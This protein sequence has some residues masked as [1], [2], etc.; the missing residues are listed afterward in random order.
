MAITEWS[1]TLSG[2]TSFYSYLGYSLLIINRMKAGHPPSR[3]VKNTVCAH[4]RCRMPWIFV[5][6][7]TYICTYTNPGA[8][9]CKLKY[10]R[11]SSC[12]PSMTRHGG[13]P[14]RV[15]NSA[16]RTH[17]FWLPLRRLALETRLK[18][19][20]PKNSGWNPNGRSSMISPIWW[21]PGDRPRTPI[22]L[23]QWFCDGPGGCFT[24][25]QI[26]LFTN[27]HLFCLRTDRGGDFHDVRLAGKLTLYW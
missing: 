27:S 26:V 21:Y 11:S 2:T 20:G 24:R 3:P 18:R 8:R 16:I 1:I 5:H 19:R 23:R 12:E 9:D 13:S 17:N 4:V 25:Y 7:H 14:S 22:S 15:S 6:V 10:P